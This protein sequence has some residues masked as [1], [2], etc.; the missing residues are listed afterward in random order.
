MDYA[1]LERD[2]SELERARAIFA[3]G[4]QFAN[5]S[6]SPEYWSTWRQFEEAHG[7][8]DTFRQMLRRQRSV[9][10]SYSHVRSVLVDLVKD[11][12][13]AKEDGQTGNGKR[14]FVSASSG[15]GDAE[16]PVDDV[17]QSKRSRKNGDDNEE[18]IGNVSAQSVPSSVFGGLEKI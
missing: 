12:N 8:E 3:H 7:N 13:Q 1:S 15:D 16:E 5:P 10:A 14:K 2:L 4:S 17:E 11:S 9:E 6:V 18:E